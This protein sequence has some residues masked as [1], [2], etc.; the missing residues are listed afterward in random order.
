MS[1][2]GSSS[3][4]NSPEGFDEQPGLDQAGSSPDSFGEALPDRPFPAPV[5]AAPPFPPQ[6]QVGQG[7]DAPT[8]HL[9]ATRQDGLGVGQPG[10]QYPAQ[11]PRPGDSA[12]RPRRWPLYVA[13]SVAAVSLL[14]AAAT[15]FLGYD[16]R[17]D[18]EMVERELAR[19]QLK[20]EESQAELAGLR[21]DYE[22]VVG[23]GVDLLMRLDEAKQIVR[24]IDHV[25]DLA[26]I[27]IDRMIEHFGRAMTDVLWERYYS[28]GSELQEARS[29]YEAFQSLLAQYRKLRNR[30]DELV[31]GLPT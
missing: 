11:P 24:E 19:T 30:F 9:L 4:G 1:G 8:D 29:H 26:Q 6:P 25:L 14:A 3:E 13:W 12:R 2:R 10:T 15:G 18:R 17:R 7:P 23:A 28:A 16:Q 22:A 20:L 27:E 5:I 21:K 31:K